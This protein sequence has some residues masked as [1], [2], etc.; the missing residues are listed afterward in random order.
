MRQCQLGGFIAMADLIGLAIDECLPKQCM[1]PLRIDA[2]HLLLVMLVNEGFYR[3]DG[4]EYRV[5][6]KQGR[7]GTCQP[8]HHSPHRQKASAMC[9]RNDL[10][11]ELEVL[12]LCDQMPFRKLTRTPI[13]GNS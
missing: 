12:L 10:F 11:H 7:Q 6:T 2:H 13:T 1:L 3:L 5:S 8:A 9:P 4:G